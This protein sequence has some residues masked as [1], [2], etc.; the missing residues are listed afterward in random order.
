MLAIQILSMFGLAISV[1]FLLVYSGVLTGNESMLP[2][3]MCTKNSCH[4]VLETK[5]ANVFKVPNFV[6]GIFYY[7]AVFLY[8]SFPYTG[9]YLLVSFFVAVLSIYLA[10]SLIYR[11]KTPC[12]LCFA[13]HVINFSIT[14]LLALTT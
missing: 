14:I 8:P 4:A 5:F 10:Y 13:S 11:L 2:K 3:N 12:F 6:L 7:L 1:Y 9:W